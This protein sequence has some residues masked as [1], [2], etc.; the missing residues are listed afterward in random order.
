[1]SGAN[2]SL[3]GPKSD[4]VVAIPQ[5]PVAGLKVQYKVGN[6]EPS[7]NA[8]RPL[9]QL[10]NTGAASVPLS[11]VTI[12]YWFT[13][14]GSAGANY[15]CDWAQLGT[16]NLAGTVR[17]VSPARVGADRYL[18]ISFKTTAGSLAAGASTGE[19]Q[20]R[21]SKS[22]WTNFSQTNDASF[23]ASRTSYADWTKVTVYRN[24]TLVWGTEP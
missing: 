19:I 4:S 7:T 9:L 5:A 8:I 2:G 24:G 10:V 3:E 21:F 11:E 12:R 16:A 13:N 18:E 20:S 22:D 17:T 15:W 23:D 14:D 6:I 1:V